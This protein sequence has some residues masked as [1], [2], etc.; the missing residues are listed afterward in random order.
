MALLMLLS[1]IH[2]LLFCSTIDGTLDVLMEVEDMQMMLMTE[3]SSW[4]TL[5]TSS[6]INGDDGGYKVPLEII[7]IASR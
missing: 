4:E 7:N 2:L 5:Q 3:A 6:A 1:F